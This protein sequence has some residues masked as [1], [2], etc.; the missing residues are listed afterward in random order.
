MTILN[1]FLIAIALGVDSFSISLAVGAFFQTIT[2]KQ[3]IKLIVNFMSFHFVMVLLGWFFGSNIL[4]YIEAFDHWLIFTFLGFI[5]GKMI[6]EAVKN[7]NEEEIKEDFFSTIN[8]LFLGLI[9]SLDALAI[10]F[11]FAIMKESVWLPNAIITFTVGM[12]ALLGLSIGKKL[13]KKFPKRIR[14]F[15]GIVLILI[16]I[17]VVL[18]HLEII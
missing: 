4:E 13:G 10:G 17:N 18:E 16:G 2:S 14:I 9:T 3:K 6:V 5:G 8:I 1:F 12:M 11:S 15:A 7:T